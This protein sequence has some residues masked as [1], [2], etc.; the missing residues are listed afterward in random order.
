MSALPFHMLLKS[1]VT[2][3]RSYST[4]PS[5][6]CI[7]S[8]HMLFS[9]SFSVMT[10]ILSTSCCSKQS[11]PLDISLYSFVFLEVESTILKDFSLSGSSIAVWKYPPTKNAGMLGVGSCS[12][13]G[14][15]NSVLMFE[16]LKNC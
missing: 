9:K 13:N 14:F 16:L 12:C 2:D 1:F 11:S 15:F 6:G 3:G 10:S 5:K 7:R 4:L 8:L